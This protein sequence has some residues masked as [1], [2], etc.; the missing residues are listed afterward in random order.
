MSDPRFTNPY[1]TPTPGTGIAPDPA[2]AVD[3]GRPAQAALLTQ[4]FLWMFVGLLR[5]RRRRLRRPG[6]PAAAGLRRAATSSS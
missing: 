1:A 3:P 4:A 6:Q 5:D 2:I